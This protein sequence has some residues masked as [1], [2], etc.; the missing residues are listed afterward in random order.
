ML[1]PPDKPTP[2][3][4]KRP[5]VIAFYQMDWFSTRRGEDLK[6]LAQFYQDVQAWRHMLSFTA[7]GKILKAAFLDLYETIVWRMPNPAPKKDA[8]YNAFLERSL[9]GP[10]PDFDQGYIRHLLAN[11]KPEIVLGLGTSA[12]EG[13]GKVICQVPHV[14]TCLFGKH[15]MEEGAAESL[16][17][18]AWEVKILINEHYAHH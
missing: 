11:V 13:I 16:V 10:A 1:I 14:G 17:N 4:F 18:L 3:V 5:L 8:I 2:A 7:S 15:P 9:G 6:K 12:Q